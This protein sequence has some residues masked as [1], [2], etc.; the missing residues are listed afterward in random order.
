[1]LHDEDI[2]IRPVPSVVRLSD[3]ERRDV[4][5]LWPNRLA[6]GKLSLIS[7]NPG[8]GKSTLS[9][10]IATH[11]SL[12][13]PWPVDGGHAPVGEALILSAED[14]LSDT[15][16][17]RLL[18]MGADVTRIHA[19]TMI[20]CRNELGAVE[21]RLFCLEKDIPL[22]E[23]QLKALPSCRLVVIDPIS[24]YMGNVDSHK[25]SDVRG[26]LA[27]LADLAQR[28]RVAVIGVT[29][30]N[31]GNGKAI[32]RTMGSV[33]YVAA[34]RAVWGI[35]ED[36]DNPG[37]VLMLP[38]KN[39]LAPRGTGLAYQ[40]VTDDRG[41][42]CIAWEPTPVDASMDEAL[43]RD[44]ERSALDEATDWLE[45]VLSAG[46]VAT[47]EL[48][49]LAKK[50][51][52]SWATLRRAKGKLGAKTEREGFGPDS[53]CYWRKFIDAQPLRHHL[54]TYD[55]THATPSFQLSRIGSNSHRCST[56]SNRSDEHV[57][58]RT[59]VF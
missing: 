3:V 24:S 40:V 2:R 33:A 14:D 17:P 37:R 1:M 38:V 4:E 56:L 47:T 55:E 29:H 22:L 23:D 16:L 27:P 10:A 20:M 49:K 9:L 18:A 11:V 8:L 25:N 53:K 41:G 59:E 57:C 36:E 13:S 45:E 28:Y 51:G 32:Y 54:S 35:V 52:H 26:V 42:S 19:L 39:N 15:I 7:G 46:R 58:E 44:D 5:W 12:G 30:L 50:A 48:Q 31:K 21:Q 6:L 34:A 43:Y